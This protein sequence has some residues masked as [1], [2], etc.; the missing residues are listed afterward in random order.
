MIDSRGLRVLFP[1]NF[2]DPCRQTGRAIAQLAAVSRLDV[3]LLHVIPVGG[4]R[5]RARQQ[6]GLFLTEAN[7]YDTCRR[8]VISAEQ[9]ATAVSELCRQRRFDVVMT[10][11]S[12]RLGMPS[13][14][15][16]PYRK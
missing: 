14:S 1:T 9:P 4:N 15:A 3:T 13:G 8:L 5:D 12:D 2:S 16:A 10:P 11:A 7:D 6:L